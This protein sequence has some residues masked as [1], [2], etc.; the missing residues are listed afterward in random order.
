VTRVQI[1]FSLI[2]EGPS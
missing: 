2:V 1:L